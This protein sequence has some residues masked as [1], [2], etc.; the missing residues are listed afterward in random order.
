MSILVGPVDFQHPFSEK[1]ARDFSQLPRDLFAKQNFWRKFFQKKILDPVL[2]HNVSAQNPAA[3]RDSGSARESEFLLPRKHAPLPKNVNRLKSVPAGSQNSTRFD[4]GDLR[5]L[6]V[7]QR[8]AFA[9]ALH[10][11][12]GGGVAFAA[13]VDVVSTVCDVD[14]LASFGR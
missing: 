11:R 6:F 8:L 4:A 12:L 14:L 1:S 3:G 9:K 7:N 5:L 10:E 13:S 2:F